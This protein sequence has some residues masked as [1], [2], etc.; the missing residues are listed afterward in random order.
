MKL[1]EEQYRPQYH[2]TP[3]EKWMNDPNGMVY[4]EGEYHLFYQYHPGSTVWGPMHWGHVI[5]EDL[6]SWKQMPIALKPDE[7]GTIF[8]GS[9]VVDLNDT[10]G[11]FDRGHGLV[12]IFTHHDECP[13]MKRVVQTQ[14]LAYS[15]DKGRTWE[16]YEGN[17]VLSNENYPDFRD[18]KVFWHEESKKWIMTLAC[19]KSLHFY[20]SANLK[21]W[22]FMSEFKKEMSHQGVWECPDLFQLPVEGTGE[23]K[24]VLILSLGID[25]NWEEGSR[26]QY[27]IGE[28][29]G[30]TF[31][32]DNSEETV[33]WLDYGRDNYAGVTW[34]DMPEEDNRRI[35]I[36][37]MNNW[38]YANVVPTENWRGAMT[39]PRELTLISTEEGVRIKQQ[40][41]KEIEKLREKHHEWKNVVIEPDKTFEKHLE[42]DSVEILVSLEVDNES[43]FYLNLAEE[44]NEHYTR[45]GY[46]GEKNSVFVDRSHSGEHD[47]SP[48][49]PGKDEVQLE[50]RSHTLNLRI[51]VDISTVEVLVNEGEKSLTYLVFP[52]DKINKVA[53]SYHGGETKIH[54]FEIY[55]LK[56]IWN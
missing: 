17:P 42:T 33:L 39:L 21:D 49:F 53:F 55:D 48:A 9:A 24:W 41:I 30:K 35:Y 54:S 52:K 1:Y 20:A 14:S 16:K 46:N 31:V 51:F 6:V 2:F 5:S 32:N 25:P 47:F 43:E 34:S 37:W 27:F 13:D 26:T 7:H 8:S 19:G 12:A 4:Y 40:P 18:P 56:G 22:E 15:K 38:C 29:D 50:S 10:T 23:L 45:I 3:S 36:A 11:F 28:F 44:G